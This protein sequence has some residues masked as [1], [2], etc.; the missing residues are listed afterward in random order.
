METRRIDNC[1]CPYCKH[2]F[3]GRDACNANMDCMTVVCPK[4]GKEMGVWL[5]VE[6]TC[7][8]IEEGE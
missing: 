4:C 1:E 2:V 7:T 5:S 3:D 6:Y 8:P